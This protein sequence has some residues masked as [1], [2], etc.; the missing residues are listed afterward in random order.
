MSVNVSVLIMAIMDKIHSNGFEL[1]MSIGK[2]VIITN[3]I[4]NFGSLA[5]MLIKGWTVVKEIYE[6]FKI[7]KKE[8]SNAKPKIIITFA[9]NKKPL[10]K[11]TEQSKNDSP[12]FS[13]DESLQNKSKLSL[14]LPK[15]T[16]RPRKA[17]DLPASPP[18]KVVI[19]KNQE[20][21]PG[22]KESII[23]Q[24]ESSSSNLLGDVGG[25]FEESFQGDSVVKLEEGRSLD[26][27]NKYSRR[28]LEGVM[29]NKHS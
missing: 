13:I 1:R 8:K 16:I 21:I 22:K 20:E 19:V 24:L 15:T 23:N 5:F 26:T 2:F 3:M 10:N 27:F 17:V 7:Q 29:Q 11:I 18:T 28:S 6:A 9:E 12:S 4:F 14:I 25:S